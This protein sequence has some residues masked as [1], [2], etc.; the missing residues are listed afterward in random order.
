MKFQF[1]LIENILDNKSKF[2]LS[3]RRVSGAVLVCA[4]RL[5]STFS[6]SEIAFCQRNQAGLG[7][8][9]HQMRSRNT[10]D[11]QVGRKRAAQLFC[12]ASRGM[13][14]RPAR[15]LEY[16]PAP[17]SASARMAAGREP[18]FTPMLL[19]KRANTLTCRREMRPC[20]LLDSLVR[21]HR[22]ILQ[23]TCVDQIPFASLALIVSL[24]E[25]IYNQTPRLSAQLNHSLSKSKLVSSKL[26][27]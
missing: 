24:V 7:R 18:S 20:M 13:L 15:L 9:C 16:V 4:S 11:F 27:T 14:S 25:H 3:R 21:R 22:A 2:A 1:F 17:N 12:P 6:A 23:P 8:T 10:Y 19:L 26:Q 5:S